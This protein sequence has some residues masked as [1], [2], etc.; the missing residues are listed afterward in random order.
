ML[1]NGADLRHIQKML[2][3]ESLVTT[4][5]YLHVVKG[6]LLKVHEQTHPKEKLPVTSVAY[7]GTYDD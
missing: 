2:G 3:H 5:R 1:R 6:D 7:R 4:Q